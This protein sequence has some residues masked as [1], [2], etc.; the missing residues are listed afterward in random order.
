LGVEFR[1]DRTG[2]IC[3][4]LFG[5]LSA[6]GLMSVEILRLIKD[7][8][9]IVRDGGNFT[10]ASINKELERLGWRERVMD[11]TSFELIT[12]ILENEYD[13]EVKRIL[14]N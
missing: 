7:V 5:R 12:F 1:R 13:Y 6:R 4:T 14:L 3:D 2:N 11:E 9:N 8:L 10:V